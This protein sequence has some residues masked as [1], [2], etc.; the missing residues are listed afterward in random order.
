MFLLQER[1]LN[2]RTASLIHAGVTP[3]PSIEEGDRPSSFTTPVSLSLH[4]HAGSYDSCLVSARGLDPYPVGLHHT[5]R[6]SR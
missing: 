3:A 2:G 1:E 6:S 5:G 4:N